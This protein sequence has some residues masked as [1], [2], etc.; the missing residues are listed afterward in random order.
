MKIIVMVKNRDPQLAFVRWLN[1]TRRENLLTT[2][3]MAIFKTNSN[4]I[5]YKMTKTVFFLKFLMDCCF[6]VSQVYLLKRNLFYWHVI[7]VILKH[8]IYFI[9]STF[10]YICF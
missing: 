3:S 7:A 10:S 6:L 8:K 9:W 5:K 2:D 1:Y 4:G